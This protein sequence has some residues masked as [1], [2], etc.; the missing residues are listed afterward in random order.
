M[1]SPKDP[2]D[3]CKQCGVI[4][5]C[6]CEVCGKIYVGETGR[7]LEERVE[8]H[9]KSLVRGDEKLTLHQ[10]KVNSGHSKASKPLIEID[11]C[12]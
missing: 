5:E 2:L 9:A 6:S 7:F 3:M 8:E 12:P 10:H 4:Y 1:V 11:H